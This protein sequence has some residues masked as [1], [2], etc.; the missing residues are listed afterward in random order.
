M[1]VRNNNL[2]A[3]KSPWT[4]VFLVAACLM[5]LAGTAQAV[6]ENTNWSIEQ[7]AKKLRTT[8]DTVRRF[9]EKYKL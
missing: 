6:W 8:P 3:L 9:I 7:I 5:S 4:G 2:C 1:L